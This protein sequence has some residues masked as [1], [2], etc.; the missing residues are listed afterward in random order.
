MKK[1]TLVLAF[2][3]MAAP[4][5]AAVTV[6][7][8]DL[9]NFDGWVSIDYTSDANVSAFGLD[10]TVDD[11]NIIDIDDFFVGECND[12]A[13]GFGIFPAS[14]AAEIDPNDP[15]WDDLNYTPVAPA[16]ALSA[17]GGLGTGGIT[18]EMGALYESGNQPGLSGRLCK[19]RVLKDCNISLAVNAIRCGQDAG[20]ND[21]GVVLEDGTAV[22]PALTGTSIVRYPSCW[23]YATQCH[24]DG[25][26]NDADVDTVDWP[27]FRDGFG[28]TPPDQAYYDNACGDFDRDGDVDTVDWPE[29]RDN[30]GK[31]P[32]SDCTPGNPH[33]IVF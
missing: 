9:G 3:L 30:F 27:L 7:V 25:Q 15:N 1:L 11:G 17:Q 28:K 5:M 33:G 18:I 16:G 23:D 31:L 6:T 29:F 20:S 19:V 21:A 8:T 24:G 14:F 32:A 12:S 26:G 2:L 13:Q 10:I 22:V 4:A